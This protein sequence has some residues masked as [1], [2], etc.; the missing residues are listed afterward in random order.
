[1][2]RVNEES[3]GEKMKKMISDS[4][5]D[6]EGNRMVRDGYVDKEGLPEDGPVS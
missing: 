5:K 6:D 4:D 2:F 3:L 1:M